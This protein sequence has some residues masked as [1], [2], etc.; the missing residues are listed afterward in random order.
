MDQAVTPTP[1]APGRMGAV[2]RRWGF[3]SEHLF[4]GVGSVTARGLSFLAVAFMGRWLG[5]EEFGRFSLAF[6]VMAL[7]A[8]L[9]SAVDNA[10]I[11]RVGSQPGQARQILFAAL[12]LKLAFHGV[13]FVA[14]ALLAGPVLSLVLRKES[15]LTL[16]LLALAGGVLTG[17]YNLALSYFRA[18]QKFHAYAF[19]SVGFNA[20]VLA[21]VCAI[22]L[23]LVRSALA[24]LLLMTGLT[25]VA[26]LGWSVLMVRDFSL[27]QAREHLRP[28]W[29]F[30]AWLGVS[31][32]AAAVHQRLDVFV[33]S[34]FADY[35]QVGK[36][37]A[38]VRIA[39]IPDL[40]YQAIAIVLFPKAMSVRDDVHLQKYLRESAVMV[41]LAMVAGIAAVALAGPLLHL[42]F[43]AQFTEA[44]EPARLLCGATLALVAYAPL[45]YLFY[46]FDR[47][48]LIAAFGL[49]KLFAA[50]ALAL[51][52]VPRY[53]AAGAA[54][55]M[56]LTNLAALL[57]VIVWS[58]KLRAQ[59]PWKNPPP[60]PA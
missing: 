39:M 15:F 45:S 11:K 9:S 21:G 56:L 3:L 17:L 43:G 19:W 4:V 59:A 37:S 7:L 54:W 44:V 48:R 22:N 30:G 42:F 26:V 1:D 36:Y 8:Q 49:F 33:L 32:L 31:T 14:G 27:R 52:L 24:N 23:L 5:P 16:Y 2:W 35:T 28:L 10:M 57:F 38:A 58:M 29:H 40:V 25:G 13:V 51:L 20:S 12:V 60:S 18:R 55:T 47:P 53:G 41:A 34:S 46:T 50:I 6:Y